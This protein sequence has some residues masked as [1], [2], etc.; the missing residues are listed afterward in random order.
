[1][2][3]HAHG[4][5]LRVATKLLAH[6]AAIF[7]LWVLFRITMFLGLQVNPTYGDIGVAAT[8]IAAV[9]YIYFGFFHRRR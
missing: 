9:L 3:S 7:G 5:G 6:A 4:R 1:M 2:P 8:G